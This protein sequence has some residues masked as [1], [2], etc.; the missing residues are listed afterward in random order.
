MLPQGTEFYVCDNGIGVDKRYH[1]KIFGMFE[2]LDAALLGSGLGLTLIKPIVQL[3]NGDIRIESKGIGHGS[4]FLFTL[5][6]AV[7]LNS[8]DSS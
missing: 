7:N 1:H 2:Q 5:P 6:A 4:C 3:Y 8:G